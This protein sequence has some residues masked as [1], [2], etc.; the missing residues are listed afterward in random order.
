MTPRGRTDGHGGPP[1]VT[2]LMTSPSTTPSRRKPW[3]SQDART[4][5]RNTKHTLWHYPTAIHHEGVNQ[6]KEALS[7]TLPDTHNAHQPGMFTTYWNFPTDT[8]MVPQVAE[9]TLPPTVT[10]LAKGARAMAHR[11]GAPQDCKPGVLVEECA[12][13]NANKAQQTGRQIH[14][15]IRNK[16]GNLRPHRPRKV[17]LVLEDHGDNQKGRE[18]QITH[19][20]AHTHLHYTVPTSNILVTYSEAQ[21]SM[22]RLLANPEG[23]AYTVYTWTR[24]GELPAPIWHPDPSW[25]QPLPGRR[26]PRQGI[27]PVGRNATGAHSNP[28]PNIIHSALANARMPLIHTGCPTPDDNTYRRTWGSIRKTLHHDIDT[29]QATLLDQGSVTIRAGGWLNNLNPQKL[30]RVAEPYILYP[31]PHGS[32]DHCPGLG[33]VDPCCEHPCPRAPFQPLPAQLAPH[34]GIYLNAVAGA[35]GVYLTAGDTADQAVPLGQVHHMAMG[36]RLSNTNKPHRPLA[37]R[38]A[39]DPRPADPNAPGPNGA[40]LHLTMKHTAQLPTTLAGEK[41]FIV[42]GL[43]DDVITLAANTLAATTDAWDD[44]VQHPTAR[45]ERVQEREDTVTPDLVDHLV[46]L[47]SPPEQHNRKTEGRKVTDWTILDKPP[48]APGVTL[49]YPQHTWWVHQWNATGI[50]DRVHTFTPETRTATPLALGDRSSHSTQH[51]YH[52]LAHWLALKTAM[53]WTVDALTRD[54]KLPR[55]WLKLTRYLAAYIRKHGTSQAGRWMSWPKDTEAILKHCTANLQEHTNKLRGMHRPRWGQGPAYSM[56]QDFNNRNAPKPAPKPAPEHARPKPRPGPEVAGIPA[57]RAKP[58]KPTPK[59]A[60]VPPPP[61]PQPRPKPQECPFFTVAERNAM[62]LEL[63]DGAEVQGVLMATLKGQPKQ[64]VWFRGKIKGRLSTPVQHGNLQPKI[65][66]QALSELREKADTQNLELWDN[67]PFPDFP[68]QL[69][70]AT[71]QVPPDT[72]WT[73]NVP[74]AWLE[75]LNIPEEPR[76]TTAINLKLCLGQ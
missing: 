37:R 60:P 3:R 58:P 46:Q 62:H 33:P 68:V 73:G 10:A 6:I 20:L 72:V 52:P 42:E 31:V 12:H 34:P 69:C 67:R 24:Y 59:A 21:T 16:D 51:S 44:A 61:E 15:P 8:G 14:Q 19:A 56:F 29:N 30:R 2:A 17:H 13:H 1:K 76:L 75:E 48:D 53:H 54:T 38:G 74:Q 23:T 65:A 49:T 28:P 64:F 27:K 9:P 66:W 25:Q 40:L 4:H 63:P 7:L 70:T 11:E 55:T 32:D 36:P 35:R 50:T 43:T 57:R 71:N 5:L 47:T 26:V 45:K 41:H 22:Y 39:R 18:V